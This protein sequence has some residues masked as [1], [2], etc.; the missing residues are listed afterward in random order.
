MIVFILKIVCTLALLVVSITMLARAND[1][2]MRPGLHW[3]VRLVGLVLSGAAPIGIIGYGWQDNFF[4]CLLYLTIF[5]VGLACVF[6]TTPY[7][8]PWW[9][10]ISGK[11]EPVVEDR[12]RSS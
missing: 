7:Q 10:Y 11:D 8:K 12:R 1:L 2:R 3:N 6:V 4:Q 5:F 9:S